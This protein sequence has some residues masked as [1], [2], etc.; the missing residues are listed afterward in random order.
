VRHGDQP[1]A[2]LGAFALVGWPIAL[3]TSVTAD[4]AYD[5]ALYFPQASGLALWLF[6]APALVALARRSVLAA[7]L[8][9]SLCLPATV[10]FVLR[11]ATQAPETIPAPAVQAM[12]ALRAAS[13]PG[14]VVLTRPGVASVPLPVV[15]AGRRVAFANYIPY[16]RQ[17]TTPEVLAEREELVR[18]FFRIRDPVEAI[19]IARQLGVRYLYLPGRPR[20]ELE[21]AG[22]LVPLFSAGREQVYR[23]AP[24][25]PA[26]GCP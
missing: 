20:Q 9:A 12:A 26:H 14:E 22:V 16:W 21:A 18:S 13:C 2:A 10:E 25:T 11:K 8:I 3:V 15:L 23:I 19:E 5:E 4:P 6:A 1:A 17:F 24:L 7:G